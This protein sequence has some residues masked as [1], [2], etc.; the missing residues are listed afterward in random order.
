MIKVMVLSLDGYN[1]W[2]VGNTSFIE[3]ETFTIQ[4][5]TKVYFDDIEEGE[6]IELEQP[7]PFTITYN[8]EEGGEIF[9]KQ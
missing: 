8:C 7:N 1:D 2:K 6:E 5:I 3:V 4:D 9:I